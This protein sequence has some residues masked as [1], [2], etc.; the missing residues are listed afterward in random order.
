MLVLLFFCLPAVG[1]ASHIVG[2]DLFY[3]HVTGNTYRITVVL[4]GDCGPASS[5]T[6][7]SLST[8]TPQV[9]VYDGATSV[10]TLSL[11]LQPPTAGVEI[12]PVCAADISSTQCTNTAFTIPGIKKFV[13]SVDYMLPYNSSVWRFVFNGQYTSAT[14]GRA[15]AITNLPT[16]PATSIQL[17]DTLNNLSF[18]ANSNPLFTTIPT[19]FFCLNELNT[20]NPGAADADGDNLVFQL[21]AATNGT[22]NCSVVGGDCTYTGSAWP[23]QPITPATPLQCLPASYSF[24]STTGQIVFNPNFVQRS[25]VVYNVREFRGGIL[26]GTC[27][28]EMTFY[29]RPCSNMPPSGVFSGAT[30]GTLTDTTTFRICQNSGPFSIN[31]YPVDPEGDTITVTASGLPTGSS[32]NTVDNTTPAPHSTFL[33]NATG[34]APGSYTFYVTFTDNNCPDAGTLTRAFTIIIDPVPTIAGPSSVCVGTTATF[35]GTPAGGTWTSYIPAVGTIGASSGVFTALA[36]GS[37]MITYTLPSGCYST[38]FFPVVPIPTVNPITGPNTVCQGS[39]ITLSNT[40]P[41]GTWSVVGPAASIGTTTGVLAGLSGGTVT[42]FYN[43]SSACGPVFASM[44]VTVNA[45]ADPGVISGPHEVCTSGPA[46][47]LTSTVV[48]GV[49]SGGAPNASVSPAGVVTGINAGTATISYTVTNDCGPVSATYIVTVVASPPDPG[50]ISGP[51][52][53]CESSAAAYTST[54]PGGTWTSSTPAVGTISSTGILT[55][56]SAGT[57]VISYTVSNSCG[58]AYATKTITVNPLATVNPITGPDTVCQGATI[59]LSNTTAGGTWSATGAATVNPTTGEVTGVSGGTAV[60]TYTVTNMCSSVMATRVV[61]VSPLPDAG[62]ISGPDTVCITSSIALTASVPGGIWSGGAPNASVSATGVVTGLISGSATI[63]Y[64]VTNSCGPSVATKTIYV[65]PVTDPGGVLTGPSTV[66]VGSS[67]VLVPSLPGGTWA[68]SSTTIATVAGGT[69]NGVAGGT[70][71]ISYTVNNTCGTTILTRAVTVNTVPVVD[72]IAGPA[73]VCVGGTIVLTNT[74][75]GGTWS[76]TGTATVSPT[77]SVGGV[78]G[79]TATVSYTVTNS[80]GTTTVT[81]IVTVNIAPDAGTISGPDTVCAMWTIHMTSTVPG[82]VWSTPSADVSISA[83]GVVTGGTPGTAIISYTVVNGCGAAT[84]V[85]TIT[86]T[87]GSSPGTITGPSSVCVGSSISLSFP[88]TGGTWTSSDIAVA[89]VT[90]GGSV[91]GISGGTATISYAFNDTC[92]TFYATRVVT[93]LPLPDAGTISGASTVCVGATISLSGSVPGGAWGASG[94]ATVSA[95]GVVTGVTDGTATI[96][97][98]VTNT[99]GSA[100]ATKVVTVIA[101]PTPAITGTAAMCAGAVATLTATPPGGTWSGGAPVASV[102]ATGVVTASA[103][104]SAV[105]SYTVS[106]SCGAV[107]AI[108]TIN[109]LPTVPPAGSI[110]GI[111]PICI[112]TT[113]TLTPSVGG[114]TWSTSDPVVAPVSGTG[115]VTGAT[116]GTAII[117]YTVTNMCGTASATMAMTIDPTPTVAPITGPASVCVGATISLSNATPGGVW[118]ATGAASVSASGVVTGVAGGIV[119]ISYTVTNSCGSSLATHIVTVNSA[120]SAGTI[121][122]PTSVCVAGSITLTS[123]VP[124]GT[125]SSGSPTAS[126]TPSGGV[127]TGISAGTALISYTVINA[128]G[129]A[130]ATYVVTVTPS[131]PAPTPIAGPAVVCAGASIVLSATPAGG[132]WSSSSGGIATVTAGG[133]VTGVS[134]GTAT[135]SYSIAGSGACGLLSVTHVVT[136]NTLPT[137]APILGP[138][139]V[140]AG[141]TISLSNATPGGTWSSSGSATVSAGGVVTGVSGGTATV[142]YTV[143]NSCGAATATRIVTVETM[144]VAG[145][146]SGPAT[147]CTGWNIT[148]TSTVP[149]GTWSGGAPNA[150]VSASGVVTGVAAGTASITYTVTNSCGA[151]TATYVVTVNAA[152]GIPGGVTGPVSVCVGSTITLSFPTT[153]GT[154][155]SSDPSVATVSAAGVVTGVSGGTATISYS[156]TGPCGTAGGASVITVNTPPVLS[157]ITGPASVCEGASITLSNSTPGGTWSIAGGAA[158]IS[159]GGVVTG[160]AAGTA[161]VT[162]TV[163]NACGTTSVTAVI[164]VDP[165]PD[166]GTIGGPVSV[167]VGGTITLTSTV[168]GGTWFGGAPNASVTPSG[169]VTGL[170]VGTTTISYMVS[171]GCGIDVATYVISIDPPPAAATISGPGTVCVSMSITLTASVPGGT[172]SS[173][174][175]AIATVSAGGV[176]TGVAP[177]TVTITYSISNACGSAMATKVITVNPLPPVSPITGPSA[178]CIGNTITLSCATPGGT[179]SAT[180]AVTV[181]AAGVVTGVSGGTGIVTYTVPGGICGPIPITRIITVDILPNAGVIS[182]PH[183]LCVSSSITLTSTIPG[184]TWSSGAPGVSV[185]AGGVVTGVLAGTATISYTVVNACGPATATYIVTVHPVPDAGTLSGP[186]SLCVGTTVTL[187]NTVSGGTWSSGAP[188]IA[189]VSGGGVVTGISGGVAVISYTVSDGVCSASAAHAVNVYPLPDPGVITGPVQVCEGNSITM[190]A[191]VPGGVWAINATPAGAAAISATGVV[192]GMVAGTATI[193]YTLTNACGSASATKVITV[194]PMPDAGTLSGPH[195]VCIGSTITLTSSVSTTGAWSS[196]NAAIASVVAGVVTGIAEGT[197]IITFTVSNVACSA[198]VSH[199]VTVAPLPA[200]GT[201]SGP[202]QACVGAPIV[203]VC[204]VPGGTWS[205]SAPAIAAIDATTGAVTPVVAGNVTITYVTAPSVFGCTNKTTYLLS[206]YTI[207][208]FLINETV[209]DTRCYGTT[210]GSISVGLTGGTG[211]WSYQWTTGATS[212]DISGLAPGSYGVNVTDNSN[213]CQKS[214]GYTVKEPDS[215]SITPDVKDE[216][217]KMAN[218]SAI[219][220]VNGGRAPYS[221]QWFD[222][223]TADRAENLRRGS[224]AVTVRDKNLCEKSTTI[225]ILEGDCDEIDV[226]TG[227]SPNGD[228]VNEYWVI[229]GLHNYPDNVVQLFDKWGDMVYEKHNYDNKW[230]GRGRTGM[231]VPDGTYFYVI[232]LNAKNG[233]GGK[234]VFTGTILVKR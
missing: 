39:T 180:G 147:V 17:I 120:P 223:S 227:I 154:W 228:G 102:S 28:R 63:S 169:V 182:G 168:P 52:T 103:A 143:T 75:P 194:D 212:P 160:L 80:C 174:S 184:G 112:G 219:V 225:D 42:V 65:R 178:V 41:G 121:S 77:G 214:E 31:I 48:G 35:T 202:K 200:A 208:P 109:V 188:G 57:T 196:S 114:G 126:V 218:G 203:L 73:M 173:G 230:D 158:S 66:C 78:S 130:V 171:N 70:A 148:L 93:V 46:I 55:G 134:G 33:W 29:V 176:V 157:P 155:S 13:Y 99:C 96:S 83:T 67:I 198:S 115:V 87:P 213:G 122:G 234:D 69:V 12:T 192:T 135:I 58:P 8:G 233:T 193:S 190:T 162:Y 117:S 166:A 183:T 108:H 21:V 54:A 141:S 226:N 88:L 45:L 30:A 138:G 23:G 189:G 37:A 116:A 195:V 19:P 167:C 24:S 104:G 206:I 150:A 5:G 125:W 43:V 131:A 61:T 9:C 106:N 74:T 81:K 215:L 222:N 119:I 211:P 146:I 199:T 72:T 133:V 85:Y 56:I 34:T 7:P 53:I 38:T 187:I 4:Y 229:K 15:A 170:V 6:F 149:G 139:L 164:N 32:F 68:S 95:G 14:A 123:T 232:K 144:P 175:V 231:P 197:V 118:S 165:L 105:I 94:S 127:V 110:T 97:Y 224:Y 207:A 132:T 91:T 163:S 64:T 153:G 221:F 205:S 2:A 50:V 59:T 142:S 137:V 76:A 10:T 44:V 111:S 25:V 100:T 51:P 179:W 98:T 136:V 217:C 86:V 216:L 220:A 156:I 40:T 177:G 159:A 11:S 36:T 152:P 90:G 22:G 161:T 128:C 79:G 129:P 60:V 3:T 82:G 27:Q 101:L 209:N 89:T 191:S 145:T 186:A 140:C 107:S 47:T 16:T 1:R 172:W 84:A 204:T 201:I 26:V 62:T 210:D 49:W 71:I 185:S 18:P 151:A 20:Y 113:T 92:G 124:G 181:S